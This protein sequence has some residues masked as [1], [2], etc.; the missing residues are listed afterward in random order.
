MSLFDYFDSVPESI[1]SKGLRGG[2]GESF[3]QLRADTQVEDFSVVL[4]GLPDGLSASFRYPYRGALQLREKLY[5]LADFSPEFRVLDLGNLRLS[6]LTSTKAS[7]LLA[8]IV[9]DLLQKGCFVLLFGGSH[10]YE[11]AQFM[12]YEGLGRQMMVTSVDNRLDFSDTRSPSRQLDQIFSYHT[13]Y[14]FHYIHL[15]YQSYLVSAKD[16]ARL[17]EMHFEAV[18]LGTIRESL[19]EVEPLIRQADMLSFDASALSKKYA[20]AAIG[21]EI[22]GLSGEEACQIAWYGGGSERLSSAGIYGYKSTEDDAQQSTAMVLATMLW[23]FMDGFQNR[24]HSST[25]KEKE[26]LRFIVD[27][28][29]MDRQIVFYK[30]LFMEKWWMEVPFSKDIWAHNAVMPCSFNDY[31]L[32]SRGEV[33]QRWLLMYNKMN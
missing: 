28:G 20:P 22:F 15:A 24:K 30:S 29:S 31:L 13:N 27:M 11:L 16:L 33:P 23:Y 17:E 12:A 5:G 3:F 21:G 10:E 2:L 4:L 18:R 14:L 9:G 26:Y 6:G 25:F 8:E 7:Y 32:A 1:Y 19:R